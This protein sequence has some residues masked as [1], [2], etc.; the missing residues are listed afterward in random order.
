MLRLSTETDAECAEHTIKVDFCSSGR[1][2]F[3]EPIPARI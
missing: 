3:Q 2:L 1:S